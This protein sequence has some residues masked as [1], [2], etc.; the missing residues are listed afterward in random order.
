MK[1]GE[2]D[3]FLYCKDGITIS[4]FAESFF[5]FAHYMLIYA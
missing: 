2:R 1:K 4:L 3:I 5:L